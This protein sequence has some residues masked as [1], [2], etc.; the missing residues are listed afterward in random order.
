SNAVC[1]LEGTM[2][3][4]DLKEIL[5]PA[6]KRHLAD[7]VR[8]RI[9]EAIMTG[10]LEPGARL[11]EESLSSSLHVSRGPVR[12]G[13]SRRE[14]EGLVIVSGKGGAVVAR[15]SLEDLEEVYSLRQAI[16]RLALQRMLRL[17]DATKLVELEQVLDALAAAC[18]RGI[19]TQ[20]AA[21][22]DL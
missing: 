2:A 22:L 19:T 15:L 16:E 3:N 8:D 10:K 17:G 7:E 1:V 12:E 11:R 5:T 6:A 4:N 20:E 21:E 13:W 9:H 18:A 14:R